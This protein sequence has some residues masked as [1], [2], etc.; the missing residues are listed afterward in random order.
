M[1]VTDLEQKWRSFKY[2]GSSPYTSLQISPVCKP[3]L[4]IALDIKGRRHVLLKVPA[5]VAVQNADIEMQNLSL[6]WH[7]ETHF[8]VMS[9]RND[10]FSDLYNDLVLSIF[11]KVKD[12][13]IATKYTNDFIESFHKWAT[14]FDEKITIQY[15]ES[16]IKGIFGELVV[17]RYYMTHSEMLCNDVLSAWLGPYGR[18]HDFVFPSFGVEV[19]TKDTNQINV[20]ISSEF[21]LQPETGKELRLAI[22]DVLKYPDGFNLGNLIQ[23]IKTIVAGKK[24]DITLFLKILAKLG[25]MG[26]TVALYNS[27]RWQPVSVT[28]YNCNSN[29]GFP[30]IIASE[31]PNTITAVMYNITVNLID[32]FKIERIML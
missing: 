28:F 4:F 11:N 3:D 2:S 27:Y 10:F 14:F 22:V 6:E 17:L 12:E 25:L 13:S 1:T 30:R 23:E 29:V 26:N 8:I 5:G 7:E 31:I 32:D 24:S 21:Q 15:T 9:L 20:R 16:E 19:K 18:A